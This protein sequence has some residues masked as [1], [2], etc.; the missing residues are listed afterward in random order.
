MCRIIYIN[1]YLSLITSLPTENATA[2]MRAWR[3]LKT[4]GAAVLREAITDDDQLLAT[5]SG[6]FDALLTAFQRETKGQQESRP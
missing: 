2:R 6:M 4:S 5:A 1:K 3:A